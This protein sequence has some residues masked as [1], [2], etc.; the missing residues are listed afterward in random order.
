MSDSNRNRWKLAEQAAI[1]VLINVVQ[2]TNLNNTTSKI[3]RQEALIGAGKAW[4]LNTPGPQEAED[5][6]QQQTPTPENNTQRF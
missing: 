6:I 5:D 4:P 1:R 3:Q 2:H